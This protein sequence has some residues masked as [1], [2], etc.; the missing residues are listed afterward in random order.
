MD[1][2]YS[3]NHVKID[4]RTVTQKR[5]EGGHLKSETHLFRKGELP[6]S[7]Q[8]ARKLMGPR[9]SKAHQSQQG[10]GETLEKMMPKRPN[11]FQAMKH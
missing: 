8:T 10:E 11:V 1:E 4:T 5:E 6:T 2:H 3:L 7:K 9:G